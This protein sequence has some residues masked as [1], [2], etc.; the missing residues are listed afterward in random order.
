MA[1][2]A[3]R[4]W[5]EVDVVFVSGGAYVDHPSFAVALLGRVLEPALDAAVLVTPPPGLEVGCV[6]IV[7]RQAAK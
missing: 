1:E 6:P 7:T 3:A 5:N 4:G 2:C